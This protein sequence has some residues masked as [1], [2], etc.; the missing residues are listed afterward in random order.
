MRLSLVSV[1][2]VLLFVTGCSDPRSSISGLYEGPAGGPTAILDLRDDGAASFRFYTNWKTLNPEPGMAQLLGQASH[3]ASSV[4]T[5]RWRKDGD[6][7]IVVGTRPMDPTV[8]DPD[9]VAMFKAPV[10]L[11]FSQQSNGDLIWEDSIDKRVS[12]LA[13]RR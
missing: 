8:T 4:E 10:E 7:I 1:F 6:R 11:E 13:K 12:R 5:G 2:T 3:Y 9:E